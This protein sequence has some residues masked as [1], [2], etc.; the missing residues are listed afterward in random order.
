M[1]LLFAECC[2]DIIAPFP[3]PFQA[4]SCRCRRHWVWWENPVAGV[5]RVCDRQAV[6]SEDT[7][8]IRSPKEC[9]IIGLHNRFL[10][11]PGRITRE[12]VTAILAATP[13]TYIFKRINSPVIRIRPGESNDTAYEPSIPAGWGG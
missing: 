5:L 11:H 7:A 8:W 9:W 4:R 6:W 12:D 13:E 1:K 3:E 2:G 10:T